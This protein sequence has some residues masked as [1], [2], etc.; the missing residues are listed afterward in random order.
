MAKAMKRTLAAVGLAIL[1]VALAASAV[2]KCPKDCKKRLA[3][4]LHGCKGICPDGKPGKA[5][6]NACKYK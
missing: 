5:C 4:E 1:C 6:K 2:A 3:I